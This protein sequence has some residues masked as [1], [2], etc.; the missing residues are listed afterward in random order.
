[1]AFADIDTAD[2]CPFSVLPH[3]P[4]PGALGPFN[5]LGSGWEVVGGVVLGGV[6]R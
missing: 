3:F 4:G 5:F 2:R 6:G 1:M